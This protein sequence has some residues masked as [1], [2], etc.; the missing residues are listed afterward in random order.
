MKVISI[1]IS[2]LS[3]FLDYQIAVTLI[4]ALATWKWGDWRN[5]RLYYPTMLFFIV[6]NFSY[7]LLTYNYPLWEFE[8]PL[9]KTTG[10]DFLIA[11][12]DFPATVLIF[13][14]HYPK[15]KIRQILYILL[16]VLTYT[17]IEIVSY[18]LGF[19]SYHNGWS[20][21]WSVLFNMILFPLLWLH[22]KKPPL[23]WLA[24]IVLALL[25]FTHFKLPFSSM[26]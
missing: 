9:L 13:L 8:S 6:G 26:K 3:I 15:E 7:T 5:W 23:A 25:F 12:V 20:I 24:S 19:F 4:L 14:P 18:K 16:W 22:H 1:Q 21:W 17:L 2:N 11:M 10:S